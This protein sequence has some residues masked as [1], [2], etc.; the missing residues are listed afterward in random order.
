MTGRTLCHEYHG[1]TRGYCPAEVDHLDEHFTGY[2]ATHAAQ[3]GL[4]PTE[5][6]A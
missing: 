3:R 4:I 6:P 2:C 5:E 1:V